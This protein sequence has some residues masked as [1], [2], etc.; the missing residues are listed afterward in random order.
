M[1]TR[2]H[3]MLQM[4]EM[5]YKMMIVYLNKL[6]RAR[7]TQIRGNIDVWFCATQRTR[8]ADKNCNKYFKHTHVD[9]M[10]QISHVSLHLEVFF[11]PKLLWH[12]NSVQIRPF[13]IKYVYSFSP[14]GQN[15]TS[16]REN[17]AGIGLVSKIVR[18]INDTY[19]CNERANQICTVTS[20]RGS[21]VQ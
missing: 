9:K 2:T 21:D 14:R 7:G 8:I 17:V 13:K 1:C 6:R 18:L 5:Y 10:S 11:Q 15:L 3:K 4:N 20:F 12:R 16:E 19:A